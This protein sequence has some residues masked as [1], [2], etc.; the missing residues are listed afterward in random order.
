MLLGVPVLFECMSSPRYGYERG[1]ARSVRFL[2]VWG[3][4]CV[5]QCRGEGRLGT[6]GRTGDVIVELDGVNVEHW[7]REEVGRIGTDAMF[8]LQ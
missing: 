3:R 2:C 6:A 4:S 8:M 1:V 5:D 7:T